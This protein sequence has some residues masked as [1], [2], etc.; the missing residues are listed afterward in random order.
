MLRNSL[1]SF[2]LALTILFAG[3]L[4]GCGSQKKT[5]PQTSQDKPDSQNST[6]SQNQNSANGTLL[7]NANPGTAQSSTAAGHR[8]PP[9]SLPPIQIGSN[10]ANS[11]TTSP[12]K[13]V[14]QTDP[15][16]DQMELVK[17]KLQ[18]LQIWLGE[19]T[20]I[21][22]KK[23]VNFTSE[24]VWDFQTDRN[25]P[26]LVMTAKKSPF[27]TNRRITYLL[28]KK[29]FQMK[30]K[31]AEGLEHVYEGNYTQEVEDVPD[32]N[33]KSQRTFKL[34]LLE[35]LPDK[36]GSQIVFNQKENNRFLVEL[37]RKRGS[38]SMFRYETIGTQR[39]GTS[40]AVSLD[41]YGERECIVSQGLGTSTV[42]YKGKTYYV[43]CSGCRAAFE[44]DPERWIAKAEERKKNK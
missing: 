36:G 35:V 17:Q 14:K 13:E 18:P 26:A 1:I 25:Q 4:A 43:C 32:D 16:Q 44:E 9:Q 34:S 37:S 20:G 40:L 24:W 30:A 21:A 10:S 15:V 41:N 6:A 2:S 42:S 31:D 3:S 11:S 29:C 8:T 23:K 12:Q 22:G 7:S 19:W 27:F 38:G 39:E 5:P 28:D 33:N